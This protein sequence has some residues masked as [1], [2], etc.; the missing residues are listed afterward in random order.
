M[1]V[2]HTWIYYASEF[3]MILPDEE[4]NSYRIDLPRD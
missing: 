2:V 3:P 4:I 1:L